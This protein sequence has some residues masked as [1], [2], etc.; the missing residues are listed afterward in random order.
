MVN[1]PAA[2]C[3]G[4]FTTAPKIG[5]ARVPPALGAPGVGVEKKLQAGDD[6]GSPRPNDTF[7]NCGGEEGANAPTTLTPLRAPHA[8][9]SPSP[10]SWETHRHPPPRTKPFFPHA[11]TTR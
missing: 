2:G 1:G 3:G 10:Q 11:K 5:P 6:A 4:F 7:S 9:D 8:T